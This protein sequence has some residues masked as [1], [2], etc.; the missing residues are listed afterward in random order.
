MKIDWLAG[1]YSSLFLGTPRGLTL[2]SPNAPNLNRSHL[3]VN[4][5]ELQLLQ[6][7]DYSGQNIIFSTRLQG[8]VF[9]I[10]QSVPISSYYFMKRKDQLRNKWIETALKS[11]T[12]AK[13]QRTDKLELIGAEIAGQRVALRVSGNVNI[14]GRLQNQKRSQIQSTFR[15]GQTTS[16]IIDQKQQLNIEGKIGDRISILVDQDS[17]RD[18]DFENALKIIYTGEEDDIVQKIEAG[19][20]SLAL[21]GT[22]FVTFSGKNNGLFGLKGLFKLGGLDITTIASVEKGKKEKLSVDGGAQSTSNFV[23]DYDYRRNLYYYLDLDFRDS[24]YQG[25]T[26]N[27]GRFTFDPDWVV[28]NL[29]VYKS[30]NVEVAGSV[31]GKAWV[32]P[33]DTTLYE[34]LVEQR[35][36]RRLELDREYQVDL[37]LGFIRLATQLQENE[38]LAVA[39]R[40]ADRTGATQAEYG[41]WNRGLNDTTDIKLKLIKPQHMVP[42]H[43]CWDLEFKN[44]YYLGTTN[45]NEQGFELKIVYMYGKDGEVE[46]D[47]SGKS[48]L[49]IFGL[50]QKDKNGNPTPDNVVDLDNPAIISLQRGE[51]WLPFLRPFQS[52]N[53]ESGERNPNLNETYSCSAMYDSNRTKINDIVADSKFKITYKY[54]NRSATISLGPMVIE[55]SESVTLDGADLRRGTDYT[56]DYFTGQ[57]TLLRQDALNPDAKLDIKYEKNQFFQLDKKTILGARA[58]YDFGENSHIGGTALYFS[59]SVID[60]KVDV[61]YEPMRNFVWDLNAS[62]NKNLNFLTRAI[63]W[64]PLISTDQMSSVSFEGE[65][66]QVLPNPNTLNNK[67]TGDPNGVG[68]IDDFEGAKRITAPPIMRR[69]WTRAAT[70]L[71]KDKI[72]AGFAFWYNPYGGVNTK[73]IWPNKEVSVRAQNN[74]TEVLVLTLDPEWATSVGKDATEAQKRETWGGI[75]YFFPTSYY[76]QSRTKFL[77]IWVMG[78]SGRL[79]VDLGQISEDQLPDG[80]LDTEDRPEAGFQMGNELLDLPDEDTGLD[81]VFDNNEFVVVQHLDSSQDTLYYGDSR[82]RDYKRSPEDPHSDNFK[83][84]NES[85][86]YRYINGTENNSKDANGLYPDTEDMN[87]NFVLDRVNDYYTI[88]FDLDNP[89][90]PYIAGRTLLNNGVPTG[91]KLYRIPLNEFTKIKEG[92][93]VTWQTI[94]AMRLWFDQTTQEDSVWI[95]K[96]E[97]VGNEWEEKG[98]AIS[99]T[100]EYLKNEEEFAITVIN[101]EDNPDIYEA[102]EGVRGEYDRINEIR[103]KEQSLVLWFGGLEGLCFEGKAAAQKDLLEDA[104]F[105][106]YR[107]MKLYLNGHNLRTADRVFY[108]GDDTPLQ[109]FIK[110]GSRV[111]QDYQF[112]ECRQMV[113]PGW[114]QRNEMLIDLDFL[115]QLKSYDSEEK[116]PTA[117]AQGLQEFFIVKDDQG[118]VVQRIYRE[119]QEGKY[120]GKEI[121]IHGSPTMAKVTRIIVG[122]KNAGLMQTGEYQNIGPVF[123]EIW[124]DEL[125]LSEVRRDPG[126]AYRARLA[127]KMADLADINVSLDRKDADFHTVEQR[128]SLRAEGLNTSQSLAIRGSLALHKFT[129]PKWGL[130]IPVTGSYNESVQTPKFIPG[131]DILTSDSPPDSILIVNRSYGV[132][133]GFEKSRSDF[134]LLKY[135]LDQIKLRMNAQ[136][137]NGSSI[138]VQQSTSETYSGSFSYS[139]PFGRDNYIEIFKW[140]QKVPVLGSKL[141]QVRLFYTP[142]RLDFSMDATSSNE[143]NNPRLGEATQSYTMG[144]NRNFNFGYKVFENLSLTYTKDMKNDMY[145]Y[146]DDKLRAIRE[147]KAGIPVSTSENYNA[148]F[149]P[150]IFSWLNPTFNYSSSYRWGEKPGSP[151]KSVDELATQNRFS[152]SLNLNMASILESVY[153]P[154]SGSGSAQTSSAYASRRGRSTTESDQK[155]QASKKP[156]GTKEIKIL[157]WTHKLLKKI[158]PIQMSYS[159]NRSVKNMGRVGIPGMRYRLGLDQ[160]PGLKVIEEEA[161]LNKDNISNTIESSIR[162]GL[163]ITSSISTSLS[164]MQSIAW[165]VNQGQRGKNINRD[166]FP[167]GEKGKDGFPFPG[168]T[169]RWSGLEKIKFLAK[170]FRSFSLDHG[171]SGKEAVVFKN[172]EEIQSSYKIYFQPLVGVSMQFKNEISSTFRFT[173][174]KT[175]NNRQGGTEIIGEQNVSA[176]VNYQKKGGFNIPIPFIKKLK[177]ENNVTFSLTAD[178]T[179]SVTQARNNESAKFTVSQKNTNWKI[180]PRVNYSFTQ[181]VTGGI[182]FEYGESANSRT[183]KRVTRN[184]GFDVNIAIRG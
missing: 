103:S 63:D 41:D 82:L 7:M 65:V 8:E 69:Y 159:M 98:I 129:P 38:I 132:N 49:Q 106:T 3:K 87:A 70:P 96:V 29:E 170:V 101:T 179:S 52:G 89:D 35:V 31:Y 1:R 116:Y 125:R 104:S 163:N 13:T 161:G 91:W 12:P 180:S 168:W 54:E 56:I 42:S 102:P 34:D 40:T 37:N 158:Q 155:D 169:L 94:R 28:S 80:R 23:K 154:K 137:R 99:D 27:G 18:F 162:S 164:Y 60:E 151:T 83:Y 110:F 76:D 134:W 75:T 117:N 105:I 131:T 123:G 130:K 100:S 61:G 111:G 10:P 2:I 126:M 26:E 50:D 51:L 173:Q 112:Y 175:I 174:G 47:Q 109:F 46:R 165:T 79:H 95:A 139:V 178:Y 127:L 182:F 144:L 176:T 141:G 124:L 113:Y 88:D 140:M 149:S 53:D 118:Q 183:G 64:L 17:E 93:D 44:V 107:Q 43:P 5:G 148:S 24:F 30:I 121:I 85:I 55:G 184:G 72:Q 45:I 172:G 67:D 57:L 11:T 58:Q 122:I 19:N 77:E 135:T 143:T 146:R 86:E 16:F 150:R 119:V 73:N 14:N 20:V 181:K 81:G 66:A 39:Y 153:K 136:W 90:H 36:F 152:S 84:E 6:E 160:D 32:N 171:F 133:A 78:N 68:F 4:L 120:S 167:L 128:P 22:Q 114:D 62:L 21:P 59:Q 115:S 97:M 15:E 156:A 74:R 25:F 177:L 108:D 145:E 71:G 138:Q 142:N 157:E 147:F 9:L 166:Y 92:G 33:N 48:F